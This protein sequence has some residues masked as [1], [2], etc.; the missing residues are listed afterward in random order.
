MRCCGAAD[1]RDYGKL[2]MVVPTT[3]Y[4][5]DKNYISAPVGTITK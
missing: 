5:I 1:F 2:G 4:T 3:C